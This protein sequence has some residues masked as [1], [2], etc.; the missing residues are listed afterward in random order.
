MDDRLSLYE[1]VFLAFFCGAKDDKVF[2]LY[3]HWTIDSSLDHR[4]SQRLHAAVQ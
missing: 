1:S 2:P 3:P 4:L